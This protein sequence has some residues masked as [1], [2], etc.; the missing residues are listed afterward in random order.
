[1]LV[2]PFSFLTGLS[3]VTYRMRFMAAKE[4]Q[5]KRHYAILRSKILHSPYSPFMD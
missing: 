2:T 3:L 5:S 4:K 1:M